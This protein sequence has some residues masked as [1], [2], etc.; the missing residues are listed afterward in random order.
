MYTS[1]EQILNW[2]AAHPAA[3]DACQMIIHYSP[4][5]NYA[6][7]ISSIQNG[8]RLGVTQGGGFGRIVDGTL[9]DPAL[10]DN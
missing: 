7:Y 4:Y 2:F 9:F 6:D 8:V 3:Y 10:P 1:V 5:G